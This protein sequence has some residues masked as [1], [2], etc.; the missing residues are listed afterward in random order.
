MACQGCAQGT[1][2]GIPDAY[3]VVTGTGGDS[4]AV[5]AE[6]SGKYHIRMSPECGGLG[7]VIGIPDEHRHVVGGGDD[8]LAVWAERHAL[9]YVLVSN[10][11]G[12]FL[13][14]VGIP[15]SHGLV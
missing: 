9:D 5:R 7:L 2:L 4:P 14:G 11:A 13:S 8:A 3:L 6:H 12:Q 10:E 15:H 1:G